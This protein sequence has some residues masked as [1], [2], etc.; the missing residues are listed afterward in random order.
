LGASWVGGRARQGSRAGRAPAAQFL[1]ILACVGRAIKQC[2]WFGQS[3]WA[4]APRGR[5]SCAS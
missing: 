5:A 3:P 4:R 2:M 1:S